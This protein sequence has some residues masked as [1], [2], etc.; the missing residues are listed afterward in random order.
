MEKTYHV[1]NASAGSGKTYAIVSQL[2]GTCLRSGVKSEAIR[3]VLALTFT[4]KAANE[5]KKRIL[6]WLDLFTSPNY[7]SCSEMESVLDYIQKQGEQLNLETLHKR[8]V[9]LRDY[10]LHHYSVLQIGT[11]D[12]F[13][14]RLVRSFAYELGLEQ[15]FAI[16]IELA[17][18][19]NQAIDHLFLKIGEEPN[20][21]QTLWDYLVFISKTEKP[22]KLK[23]NLY[24][25]GEDL[26]KDLNYFELRKNKAF[27]WDDFA[28]LNLRI[29]H[30]DNALT[31]QIQTK[32]EACWQLIQDSG[33]SLEDFAGGK[34]S[35]LMIKVKK[36]AEFAKAGKDF[37][38][39]ED[40]EKTL[41]NFRKVVSAKGKKK[42]GVEEA[43]LGIL[44]PVIQLRS[45]II[46]HWV[47]LFKF[48]LL[49][50][51]LLPLILNQKIQEELQLVLEENNAV[52]LS[53]FNV[54]IHENLEKEP[55]PFIYEKLGERFEHYYLDE[56]QDTSTLQWSNILP[57]RDD[58]IATQGKQFSLVGDPKQSIYRFRGGDSK[59]FID[60]INKKEPQGVEELKNIIE[61]KDNYRSSKNI[62][63]FN[64]RLYQYI[65]NDLPQYAQSIFQEK[66]QQTPKTDFEGRVKAHLIQ[67]A[68]NGNV[69]WELYIARLHE[70]IQEALD[71]GFEFSD[72]CVLLRYNNEIA[73][74]IQSLGNKKVWKNNTEHSIEYL[75]KEGLKIKSSPTVNAL[76]QLLYWKNNP[77]NYIYFAD[78]LYFLNK[79]KRIICEDLSVLIYHLKDI[80][81]HNQLEYL[82]TEFHL[83][84]QDNQSTYNLYQQM[85]YFAKL[86]G[87]PHAETDYVVAF[88][89]AVHEFCQNQNAS[90]AQFLDFWEEKSDKMS[91]KSDANINALRFLTIH[92]SKGL[93]FPIVFLPLLKANK[94]SKIQAWFEVSEELKGDCKNLKSVYFNSNQ[95]NQINEKMGQYDP[96]IQDFLSKNKGYNLVD[97]MCV[98]YVA[99]TRAEQQLYLYVE[100][101]FKEDSTSKNLEVFDYLRTQ[102]LPEIRQ[103][104]SENSTY[105]LCET[106]DGSLSFELYELQPD[107][108]K[109][110]DKKQSSDI[111]KSQKLTH[112]FEKPDSEKAL[113]KIA[114]PS[115]KYQ[116]SNTKVKLGILIHEIFEKIRTKKD[117]DN[118]LEDY[119][120]KGQ[121]TPTE[122]VEIKNR[123]EQIINNLQYS[124]YFEEGVESFNERELALKLNDEIS[125]FRPDRLVKTKEGWVIIDF[126]TG[127]EKP[128]H[129]K[130]LASYQWALEQLG[131]LVVQAH[132]IYL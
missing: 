52:L 36:M 49:K 115:R 48:K 39:E 50:R 65:A 17:P 102:V 21:T 128:E 22:T 5:M 83:D 4:N 77:T 20:L 79:S 93:E 106:Q 60:I 76:I 109:K 6:D 89:E 26:N 1:I 74:T 23:R 33:A 11:L 130:Q 104:P 92:D 14:S 3:R 19:L 27:D 45:E 116:V 107:S 44:E 13:N 100:G 118:V 99:T 15:N 105:H 82:K 61:L 101:T 124:K 86:F 90:T 95:H 72:M 25:F 57:L 58:A 32:I 113:L 55:I 66:A 42:P 2:L 111:G 7:A 12:K 63:N 103:K 78:M 35:G 8:A 67:N 85:E 129:Q 24:E 10:L 125:L 131:H 62:V 68:Q 37:P 69:F 94:D 98:Q 120:L 47:K 54:L 88:L 80:G 121:I 87:V 73:K 18:Y 46:L 40:E 112:A 41:T 71:N 38:W 56:F 96:E 70:D 97:R 117:V 64:N 51:F 108:K 30:Q 123:I 9:S 122:V 43:I 59:I 31:E 29:D 132:L 114:N 28:A 110:R 119:L 34:S 16:D 126:K 75:S 53:K 84:L 91:I 127:K 81:L